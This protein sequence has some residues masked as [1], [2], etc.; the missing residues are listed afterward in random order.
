MAKKNIEQQTAATIL[1]RPEEF[2]IDGEAFSVAPPCLETLIIAS[3]YIAELPQIQFNPDD[4]FNEALYL[5]K[6]CRLIGDICAVLILG[7][8]NMKT[9]RTVKEKRVVKPKGFFP[10]QKEVVAEVDVDIEVDNVERLASKLRLNYRPSEVHNLILER[11]KRMEVSAFF[12][13]STSLIEINLLRQT[14]EV[15]ETTASGQ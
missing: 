5:A 6:D 13:L 12:G 2:V 15:E 9:V 7:A 10:W 3:E 8:K 11:L 14:R 4:I 1:Q